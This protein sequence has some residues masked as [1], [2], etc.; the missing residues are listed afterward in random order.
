MTKIKVTADYIRD[1]EEKTAMGDIAKLLR[2]R[3]EKW[4]GS[5]SLKDLNDFLHFSWIKKDQI[6]KK[7][8]IA[9]YN[10]MRG[11][12]FEEFVKDVIENRI[13]FKS[14]R[15]ELFWRQPIVTEEL[16]VFERKTSRFKTYTKT[17]KVDL[18]LGV[19]DDKVI[20][21]FAIVS[22]KVWYGA[23]WLDADRDVFDRVKSRYPHVYGYAI[24]LNCGVKS[25]SLISAQRTGMKIYELY[26][27]KKN[28]FQLDAFLADLQL[29]MS[30]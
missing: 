23:D 28:L 25:E 27:T 1:L 29:S 10:T 2:E 20:H 14:K 12:S 24:C 17:K 30:G 16:Y 6:R 19:L 5:L 18:S 4:K 13:N 3:Y 21:P 11:C 8:G 7:L 22:C 26:N 9:S 15:F